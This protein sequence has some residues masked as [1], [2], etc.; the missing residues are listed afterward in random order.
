LDDDPAA[1]AP[2]DPEAIPERQEG[3]WQRV[4]EY[5][6]QGMNAGAPDSRLTGKYIAPGEHSRSARRATTPGRRLF[7]T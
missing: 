3:F 7:L 5:W 6:W 2:P 4:G 1:Y